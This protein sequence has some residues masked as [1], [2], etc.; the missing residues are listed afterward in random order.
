MFKRSHLVTVLCSVTACASYS[1]MFSVCC[2]CVGPA[3]WQLCTW[4]YALGIALYQKGI[5]YTYLHCTRTN[6]KFVNDNA[7]IFKMNT[8]YAKIASQMFQKA[9]TSMFQNSP[10]Y[11]LLLSLVDIKFLAISVSPQ[12]CITH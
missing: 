9:S 6:L 7:I 5:T 3:I 11:N 1:A 10:K 12:H 8:H 4:D 2:I